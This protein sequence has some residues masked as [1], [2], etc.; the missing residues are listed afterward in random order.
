MQKNSICIAGIPFDKN[1]SFLKGAALAPGLIRKSYF[2]DSSNLWSEKGCNLE[3]IKSLYDYG[4]LGFQ[5]EEDEFNSITK[6]AEKV[7]DQNCRLICLGG[8]H[9]ITYPLIKA[10]A[11]KYNKL[12]LLHFD[13]H[14]D[15]YDTLQGNIHSHATVFARI[16]ENNL[17]ARLVQAGIRTMNGHQK[18]QAEKFNVEVHEMKD[19]PN[20]PNEFKFDGPVY[21]SLDLDCLDPAFAPGV[22]HHEPGGM[23]TRQVIDIIHHFKGDLIGADIVEYNPDR[24]INS[25]TSMV[26]AKFLKEIIARIYGD[27]NEFSP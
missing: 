23:T 14:P 7:V 18:E 22:S 4:D 17:A 12:N 16:M 2:S 26:A 27:T 5:V 3:S 8:D 24:D 20:W 25:M 19:F 10:H 9:S 13:A 1:S 15:L 21:L 6:F 11:K